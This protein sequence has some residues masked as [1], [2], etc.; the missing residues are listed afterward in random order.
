MNLPLAIFLEKADLGYRAWN[1]STT[2]PASNDNIIAHLGIGIVSFT[3]VDDEP[4]VNTVDYEYR[5][6]TDVIT[7][8]AVSG[9]QS[10]PDNPVRVSFTILGTTYNVGNVYYPDGD[11]QL[12]WV[13]WR[14]PSAPQTVTIHVSVTGGGGI[15][16]GTITAQITD[17][18]A[19]D[20]PNP[21]ADD[22]NDSFLPASIPCKAQRSNAS[23]GVWRPWWRE[24]WVWTSEWVWHDYTDGGGYWCDHGYWED[25]GWWEFAYNRYNASL[26]ASMS[27]A[28]DSMNPTASGRTM[29]SGYGVNQTVAGSV[30]TN[31]S[32]A[33]T[34]AQNA[35]TYFP[36]FRYRTYWRLLD[37][38]AG[39]YNSRF[40]FRPNPYSTYNRRTHFTPIWYP[41]GSYTL[42]T[43]L[44]DSWTPVG[45]LSVNLTDNLT[46]S[47]NL[48]S[49][50]HIAP[51]KS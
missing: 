38:I 41:D 22:R 23:W 44:M 27:I 14:T 29:K 16:T 17:L 45:M 9:G 10:D 7:S 18:G 30:S 6:N 2:Q 31:Q 28:P 46:I 3:E 42:Y 35:V 47:G 48:W 50:W 37:R 33:V 24:N 1:G 43:W 12:A 11:S 5:V 21:T 15:S 34:G 8:V 39:G 40:E 49:D 26:S 51:Q 4:V 25:R 19:N 32:S 13:R 36:E 20:P